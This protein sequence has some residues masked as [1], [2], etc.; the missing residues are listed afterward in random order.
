MNEAE[1]PAM[2]CLEGLAVNAP[3]QTIRVLRN[4]DTLRLSHK[5]GA[6]KKEDSYDH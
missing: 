5:G 4:G 2:Q 3:Y 1:A 6:R